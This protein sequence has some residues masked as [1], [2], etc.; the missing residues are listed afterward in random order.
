MTAPAQKRRI[1]ILAH[2]TNPRGGVVH[3]LELGDALTRLGHTAVVHAP[4]PTGAGFFRS[5]V[6]ETIGVSATPA[7]KDTLL[8]AIARIGD[9]VRHFEREEHRRFDIFHAQDSISG[10]ALASLKARGLIRGFLRTVHHVDTFSDPRLTILQRGGITQADCHF[11][12]SHL[13]QDFLRDEW[14]IEA[15]LVGNGVDPGR[16]NPTRDATDDEV[17]DRFGLAPGAPIL[18]AVG[19]VEARK[20]TIR[21][22]EAFRIVLASSSAAR[23][24]IAGGASLLDHGD[25][26]ARFAKAF[27]E[28]GLSHG[29]VIRTGPIEQR[30]MPALYRAASALMFASVKEGF[31]LAVLEAM[32]CGTPVVVSRIA[33]FSEYIGPD[34]VFWCDPNDAASI[35]DAASRSIGSAA[36]SAIIARGLRLA[37]RHDW[38][39]C[40]ATH[41]AAY[42]KFLEPADA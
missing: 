19:G 17:R 24:L 32:A 2:S 11:V 20:N 36:R 8:M 9:Y 28:S 15:G 7:E 40:A 5:S 4:D 38:A 22:L 18:L 26:Q 37:A 6:C 14:R 23:F 29:A 41:L 33:P 27:L 35:A 12:V 3:A 16:F 42:E 31:G 10:N 25:Y 1:A 30:L 13:W 21:M 34:D 39:S